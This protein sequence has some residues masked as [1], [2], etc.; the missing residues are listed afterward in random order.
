MC[1]I[2]AAVSRSEIVFTLLKGLERLEYRGYDSAGM[3]TIHPLDYTIERARTQGKVENLA[4]TLLHKPLPGTV[5]IAHTRWATHGKPTVAN[6]HPQMSDDIAVV[7]NGI[8]ENNEALKKKLI[9]HGY[10]FTSDTDTEIAAHLIHLHLKKHQDF[11]EAVQHACKELV[12]S[13]SFG[14]IC[15]RFPDRLIGVCSGSPLVVGLGKQENFI[16]SDQVALL[17]LAEELVYLQEGDIVDVRLSSVHIKNRMGQGVNRLA[18]KSQTCGSEVNRGEFRHYMLKEIFEQPQTVSEALEGRLDQN[19]IAAQA[20]GKGGQSLF[21]QI[22]HI[23]IVAC[24]S[25]YHAGL[26]AKYWLEGLMNMPCQVEVASEFR[27]RK[28]VVQKNTL[29]LT[30]SQS[31]ET[32]DTIA[33]LKT[34]KQRGFFASLAICNVAGSTLARLSDHVFLIRAGVEV[35]VASTKAFTNQLVALLMLT[36]SIGQEKACAEEKCQELV[37]QLRQLPKHIEAVL[38]L[39]PKIEQLARGFANKHHALFLGRGSQYPVAMEGALKLKEISYIHAEAYP[40]GELK[41]GPLALVDQYMP[42]V[43]VAPNDELLEKLRSN[44]QEVRARGGH[45]LVFAD[46]GVKIHEAS[47]IEIQQI[48]KTAA[49]IGPIIYNIPLQ[50]LAYYAALSKGTDIDQP[51][52]LAKSVTVE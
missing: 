38:K 22:E 46:Q 42:I 51:R 2:V 27:Y 48:P 31:G 49:E 21:K 3:A 26:I 43:A 17:G 18:Q 41:H 20:F 37:K 1:G 50:L 47:Q 36:I 45:L 19:R 40:A 32:A 44:L 23:Q 16:A 4:K 15:S 9:D 52:N 13:F 11:A 7:H 10:L 12:G 14:V 25:S 33:A 24:G 29:F 34:A 5:G 6:A 30:L 39:S 28:T 35:G 8:I